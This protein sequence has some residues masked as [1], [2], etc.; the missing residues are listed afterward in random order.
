MRLSSTFQFFAAAWLLSL[1]ACF[2]DNGEEDDSR[3]YNFGLRADFIALKQ[4]DT[5]TTTASTTKP[6]ADFSYTGSSTSS[7]YA[8][9][10]VFEMRVMK[11]IWVGA[12]LSFHH[13]SYAQV[14]DIRTGR[15]DPNAGTDN[16]PLTILTDNSTANYWDIPMLVRY[17]GLRES[18]KFKRFYP[19]AGATYRH[20]GR[21]RTGNDT[22]N[23]DSST[24]YNE[25]PDVPKRTNLFGFTAGIGF[26][27]VDELGVKIVPEIRFTRWF[28]QSFQGLSYSS[29]PNQVQAGLGI[30]F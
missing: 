14:T 9:G 13:A 12:E 18:G 19:L 27:L 7:H 1:P 4:F 17:R 5:K 22:V 30:T 8:G 23:A 28:D 15:A 3:K 20:V 29:S 26:R 25:I 6:I 24:D 2:A 16:R 11:H 21:V 10:P